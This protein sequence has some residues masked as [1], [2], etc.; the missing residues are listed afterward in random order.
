L[1]NDWDDMQTR[2]LEGE[3]SE[4]MAAPL[5]DRSARRGGKNAGSVG[6]A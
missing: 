3:A 1:L 2:S 4:E 6:D 5:A